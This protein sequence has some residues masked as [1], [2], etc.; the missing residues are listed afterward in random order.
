MVAKIVVNGQV[1]KVD[2][3]DPKL[4]SDLDKEES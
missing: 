3:T 2:A 1:V 4:I